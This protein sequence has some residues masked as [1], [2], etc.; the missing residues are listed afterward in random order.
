MQ[1]G[2]ANN[3]CAPPACS[4]LTPSPT[5]TSTFRTRYVGTSWA[6][7]R[8]QGTLILPQPKS[9]KIRASPN[10][11]NT[12]TQE[13]RIVQRVCRAFFCSPGVQLGFPYYP[14]RRA[15]C[16][17]SARRKNR[18]ACSS[19][20]PGAGVPVTSRPY[21][22]PYL[23]PGTRYGSLDYK[24]L[25]VKYLVPGMCE[26]QGIVYMCQ[27]QNLPT[28]TRQRAASDVVYELGRARRKHIGWTGCPR[29]FLRIRTGNFDTC[30]RLLRGAIVNRTKYCW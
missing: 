21:G 18:V 6:A 7:R 23:V 16:E 11:Q 10:G 22:N 12:Q 17:C 15:S 4:R 14:K 29:R 25:I 1:Y 13:T 5:G 30:F 3:T 8:A 26:D 9:T 28:V 27:L 24:V 20:I 2:Y 19:V